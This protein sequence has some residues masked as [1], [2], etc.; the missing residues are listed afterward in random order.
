MPIGFVKSIVVRSYDCTDW[1]DSSN[2]PCVQ[3][4]KY[5]QAKIRLCSGLD[6]LICLILTFSPTFQLAAATHKDAESVVQD[7]CKPS[8]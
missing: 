1:A 7:N 5:E 3:L 2:E 6:D 8:V 4:D